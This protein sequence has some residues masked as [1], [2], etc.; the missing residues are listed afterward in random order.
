A[1]VEKLWVAN[2]KY[3][4]EVENLKAKVQQATSEN[5]GLTGN[6]KSKLDSLASDHQKFLEDLKA[7]LNSGLGAQ[8][9]IRELKAVMEGIKMEDQL[10]L[11]NLQAKHNI[12][13]AHEREGGPVA[14][15]AGDP[16]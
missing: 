5:M 16:E 1:E 6:W 8:Q 15:A 3:T 10:E 9:K 12:E 7:T 11:G 13:T 4:Q 14:E 2:E